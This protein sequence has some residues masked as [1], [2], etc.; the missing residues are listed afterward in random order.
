MEKLKKLGAIIA[1]FAIFIGAGCGIGMNFFHGEI[2]AGI[3]CIIL[4]LAAVPTAIYLF[5][6]LRS[7]PLPPMPIGEEFTTDR[8]E[9]FKV[10]GAKADG[11]PICR[12][13][14]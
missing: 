8:G 10:V 11:T 9:V 13:I 4:A 5:N 7:E 12:R 2:V 3:C 6:F 1:L 14:K